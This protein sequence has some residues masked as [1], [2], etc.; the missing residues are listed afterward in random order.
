MFQRANAAFGAIVIQRVPAA[1][2]RERLGGTD[3]RR[4]GAI[5]VF[6]RVV[7]G[8][9]HV[10]LL[11]RLR[12]RQAEHVFHVAVQQPGAIQLAENTN[13]ATRTVD[14]FHVVLLGTRRD[15][16]QLRH[17]A[18]E[19]VDVAHGEVDFSFLR[20]GQQVQNGVGGTAHGDIQR[21][22]VF[23]RRFA[24]DVTRQRAGVV[25]LVVAF[26]QLNDALARVKE[27]LFTVG[28]GRQQRAVT[29]LRKTQ[30]FGQAVHG[31]GGEH[32][33]TGA[34]GRARGAFHLV[35]LLVSDFRIRALDHRIDQVELDDFVG[36]LGFPRF[37]WA[38]RNED[39]RN[40]QAQ[41][42]HQHPRGDFVAVGD[43]DHR[44]G[45]VGINHVLHR[46]GDQLARR[47]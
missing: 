10:V 40:V 1:I 19:L 27:Q 46:V 29:R 3:A 8:Q 34:A 30:R 31:V 47:Q 6:H 36:E 25:L 22:G 33:G 20:G 43:T 45:A 13:H 42:S 37:H 15:F 24:G 26:G 16:T 11:Q 21:H 7:F 4:T 2:L 17:F 32:P 39:H 28:V 23:E 12:Q 44:I 38:T 35:A 14:I 5:H 41:G 18:G 9:H